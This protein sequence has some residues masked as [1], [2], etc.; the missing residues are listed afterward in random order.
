M[1]HD[2]NDPGVM[3]ITAPLG[4]PVLLDGLMGVTRATPGR[5]TLNF[6]A[7]DVV[8]MDGVVEYTPAAELPE[9]PLHAP[10]ELLFRCRR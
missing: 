3:R 7:L 6:H 10:D 5:G 4:R 1:L 9:D 2:L 8:V